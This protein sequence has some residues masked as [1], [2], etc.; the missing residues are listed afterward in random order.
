MR[1]QVD[2]RGGKKLQLII[3]DDKTQPNQSVV[4]FND[5]AGQDVVAVIGSPFS[6]S[7]LATIPIAQRKGLPYVSTAASDQQVHPVRS[8]AFMTPPTAGAAAEG[9]IMAAPLA[10][11]GPYL[12]EPDQ[13]KVVL[14]MAE[15]FQ[16]AN[17]DYPPQFAFDGYS[18]VK[19]PAEAMASERQAGGS[20]TE[21]SSRG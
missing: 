17:G 2:D 1:H 3:T 6:N 4:N 7:A 10:V 12:P 8:Y 9:V 11:I 13:K 18:A 15:P 19:L 5:L 20:V 14:K 16:R 21:T